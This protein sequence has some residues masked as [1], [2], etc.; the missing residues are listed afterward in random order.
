ME[1]V[2]EGQLRDS[3]LL[4]GPYLKAEWK[5][6]FRRCRMRLENV[7][8]VLSCIEEKLRQILGEVY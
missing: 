4:D 1:S 7:I 8:A 5:L 3:L 2:Q 6:Y